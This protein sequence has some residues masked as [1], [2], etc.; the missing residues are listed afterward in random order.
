MIALVSTVFAL[1]PAV[2]LLLYV[3]SRGASKW[4][5]MYLI[6]FVFFLF[7]LHIWLG[8]LAWVRFNGQLAGV[9]L[10]EHGLPPLEHE[11]GS[12]QDAISLTFL[13]RPWL[14]LSYIAVMV[15]I[16]YWSWRRNREV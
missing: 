6:L 2:A 3:A 7:M 4:R 15:S 9:R 8:L 11:L 13:R 10:M 14:F 1:A 12:W 5:L 16:A